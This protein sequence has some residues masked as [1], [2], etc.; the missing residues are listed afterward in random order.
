MPLEQCY[1][2]PAGE[3]PIIIVYRNKPDQFLVQF[4]QEGMQVNDFTVDEI[5]VR[6]NDIASVHDYKSN[7]DKAPTQAQLD[8]FTNVRRWLLDR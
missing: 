4:Q 2:S 8:A 6:N 3:E 1:V 7:V 5:L